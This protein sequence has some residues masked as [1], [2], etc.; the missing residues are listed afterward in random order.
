MKDS[1]GGGG[2]FGLEAFK[3]LS[4]A[5]GVLV[6][7]VPEGQGMEWFKITLRVCPGIL[8]RRDWVGGG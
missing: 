1:A 5:Q 2:R 8:R 6:L 4:Y 3:E 7:C